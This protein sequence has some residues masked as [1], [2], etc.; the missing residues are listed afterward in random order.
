MWVSVG[1]F[2]WSSMAW[3]GRDVTTYNT[4][5]RVKTISSLDPGAQEYTKIGD[6]VRTVSSIIRF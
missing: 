6:I 4:V 3:C 2:I 5:R 1:G